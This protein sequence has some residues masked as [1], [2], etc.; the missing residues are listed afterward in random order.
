M[1]NIFSSDNTDDNEIE[2]YNLTN[3]KN[4]K[5]KL[6]KIIYENNQEYNLLNDNFYCENLIN[7]KNNLNLYTDTNESVED[8]LLKILKDSQNVLLLNY[9]K[10][11]WINNPFGNDLLHLELLNKN[12]KEIETNNEDIAIVKQKV[13]MNKEE[14]KIIKKYNCE[15]TFKIKDNL[16]YNKPK[17]DFINYDNC[18]LGY[19]DKHFML[20]GKYSDLEL[21]EQ[22]LNIKLNIYD[23]DKVNGLFIYYEDIN[24]NTTNK[25]YDYKLFNLLESAIISMDNNNNR[26]ISSHINKFNKQ[27][28][29][30]K[31]K[32]ILCKIGDKIDGEL[33]LLNEFINKIDI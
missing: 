31:N 33:I 21:D 7:I 6:G 32:K 26:E 13:V 1:G 22:K 16:I 2:T 11:D 19:E 10:E 27:L 4:L 23:L 9:L 8:L 29:K 20:Y 24:F 25:E 28:D 30:V 17:Y 5:D 12:I 3:I 14:L 18:Y 15:F